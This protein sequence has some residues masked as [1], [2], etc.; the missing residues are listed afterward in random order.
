MWKTEGYVF[1]GSYKPKPNP[2]RRTE[3]KMRRIFVLTLVFTLGIWIV[4]YNL[5]V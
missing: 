5:A 3:R 2:F 1:G 4:I